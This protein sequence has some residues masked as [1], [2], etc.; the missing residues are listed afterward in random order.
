MLNTIA[1]GMGL[2]VTLA[3]AVQYDQMSRLWIV[4]LSASLYA[5]LLVERRI[6]RRIFDVPIALVS[7][8]DEPMSTG[9]RTNE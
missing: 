6:A 2:M 1:V 9:N 8:V 7:I 3:F 4:L 5:S